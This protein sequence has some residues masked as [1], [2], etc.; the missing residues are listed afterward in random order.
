MALL[1]DAG[2]PISRRS[3]KATEVV[4][5]NVVVLRLCVAMM[6]KHQITNVLESLLQT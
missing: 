2:G 3:Q 1:A 6:Y 5:G 4:V